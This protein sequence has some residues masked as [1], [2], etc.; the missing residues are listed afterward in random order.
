MRK[1]PQKRSFCDL[2]ALFL[3]TC[4]QQV[5]AA[6]STGRGSSSWRSIFPW[7]QVSWSPGQQ[8]SF[9]SRETGHQPGHRQPVP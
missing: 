4:R 8:I 2:L 1:T 5:S 6:G 9:P 7:T 3:L